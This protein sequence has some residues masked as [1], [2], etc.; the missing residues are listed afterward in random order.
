MGVELLEG[1]DL[2]VEDDTVYMRTTKGLDQI[3]VLYRRIDDDLLDPF[4]FRSDSLLGVPGLMRAYAAGRVALANAPGTGIADD[5]A[6]YAFVPEI[7]RY[8]TGEQAIG[9]EHVTFE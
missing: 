5:K 8:Y 9:P 2:V 4:A 3:D 1:S 7:I 6:V